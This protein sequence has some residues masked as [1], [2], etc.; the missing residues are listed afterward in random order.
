[1]GRSDYPGIVAK[2]IREK[3]F[4]SHPGIIL[5]IYYNIIVKA[6][7]C[8]VE[9]WFVAFKYLNKYKTGQEHT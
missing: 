5:Q 6:G 3:Q 8:I 2:I 7:K 4:T 1:M 9:R